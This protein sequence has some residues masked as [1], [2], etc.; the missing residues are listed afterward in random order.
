M[1]VQAPN[2]VVT[3]LGGDTPEQRA[4]QQAKLSTFTMLA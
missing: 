3:D 2:H 4:G 1:H